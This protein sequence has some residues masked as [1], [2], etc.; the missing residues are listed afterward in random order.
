[1]TDHRKTYLASRLSSKCCLLASPY[2]LTSRHRCLQLW[3]ALCASCLPCCAV[4]GGLAKHHRG[5]LATGC[6]GRGRSHRRLLQHSTC[7]PALPVRFCP[8]EQLPCRLDVLELAT[9]LSL[10]RLSLVSHRLPRRSIVLSSRNPWHLAWTLEAVVV[11]WWQG[12]N[13]RDCLPCRRSP[14]FDTGAWLNNW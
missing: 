13:G 4:E 10:P 11:V 1:M 5:G 7:L 9:H 14:R 3:T 12:C 8:P 6:P 2:N